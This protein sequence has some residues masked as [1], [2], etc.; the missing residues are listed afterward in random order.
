MH[1]DSSQ[2]VDM[3]SSA[4][5]DHQT[6]TSTRGSW[7]GVVP[8]SQTLRVCLVVI[9]TKTIFGEFWMNK[10]KF[11]RVE[12]EQATSGLTCRHSSN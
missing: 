6:W 11:T 8:S 2:R 1:Y 9:I 5:L 10:E 4:R 7:P 3:R 12:F